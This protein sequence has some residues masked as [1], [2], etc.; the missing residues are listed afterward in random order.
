MSVP[1]T[2]PFLP[3]L[4]RMAS[5]IDRYTA[6]IDEAL[7]AGRFTTRVVMLA[8]AKER[9]AEMKGAARA[10]AARCDAL[11]EQSRVQA[12]R[13]K[14]EGAL[15]DEGGCGAAGGG[16]G[17]AWQA[18][19]PAERG[20]TRAE[21]EKMDSPTAKSRQVPTRGSTLTHPAATGLPAAWRARAFGRRVTRGRVRFGRSPQLDAKIELKRKQL[22][23]M[24][25]NIDRYTADMKAAEAVGRAS[26]RGLLHAQVMALT[27]TPDPH[28]DPD[29]R[30]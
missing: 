2:S 12:R 11:R 5:N 10:L 8:Q 14:D 16:G 28:P 7:A 29:P 18:A 26:T 13:L 3:Q 1:P 15:R 24:A 30:P 23:V 17:G 19:A 25:C 27:L 21:E 20:P 6:E 22:V 9:Y 4:E